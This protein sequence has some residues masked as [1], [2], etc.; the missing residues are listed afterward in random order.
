MYYIEPGNNPDNSTPE[1]LD[2][3]SAQT[4]LILGANGRFGRV[5]QTAFADAGWSVIAQARGPLRD[6]TDKRVR[7]LAVDAAQ[8]AVII[9]AARDAVVVVNALNPI[10]TRW[11]EEA[12]WL[13]ECAVTVA[14]T[15]K[16]T[17]MLPGNVYNYGQSMPNLITDST[18]EQP[19]TRKGEIRCEMEAR[20][21]AGCAHSIVV[22]AGDFFGGP[23]TGSWMDQVIAKDILRGRIT[24]PGPR[25]VPHA[26]A[27]LPDLA[28]SFVLLAQMRDKLPSHT[29]VLFPGYTLTGAQLAEALTDAAYAIGVL[30]D[31]CHP[32]IRTFRWGAVGV[33]R[34][35]N[36]MMREIWRMRYLWQV[37]H[38]LSGDSLERVIGT[39]P[40]TPVTEALRNSLRTL[41]P[42]VAQ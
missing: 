2:M 19:S 35:F 38:Q 30:E 5:A 16:A 8:P 23:G 1:P 7:H 33:A 28:R 15:L 29:N 26:W 6:T 17:L 37:P 18:I 3:R 10:Y 34:F 12:L 24:Y 25:E 13:N 20:M 32:S 41:L 42:S 22:R 14:R 21:R 4:V 39:V 31:E 11:E 9:D 27:Y 36:P 40:L